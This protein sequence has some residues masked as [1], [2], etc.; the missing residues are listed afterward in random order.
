MKEILII[1]LFFLKWSL[2]SQNLILNPSFEDTMLLYNPYK[3]SSKSL[4]KAVSWKELNSANYYWYGNL[5]GLRNSKV[6]ETKAN[7]GQCF[8][9]IYVNP[10]YAVTTREFIIGELFQPLIKECQ[11]RIEIFAKVSESYKYGVEEIDVKC[12]SFIPNLDSLSN[13]LSLKKIKEDKIGWIMYSGVYCA[14]GD[15]KF[16]LIGSLNEKLKIFN[17]K[18][19]RK[20]RSGIYMFIDDVS[21]VPIDGCEEYYIDKEEVKEEAFDSIPVISKFITKPMYFE[22]NSIGIDSSYYSFLDSTLTYLKKDESIFVKINGYTDKLGSHTYN[23]NLSF[24]RAEKVAQYL[25]EKGI[26]TTRVKWYGNGVCKESYQ[27]EWKYRKVE[28][29]IVNNNGN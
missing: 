25:I 18:K 17:N 22:F 29:T 14:S 6:I 19:R 23:D 3:C 15:E 20:K 26:S 12:S 13:F 4:N 28:I 5:D 24:L 1:I 8:A 11:Y 21:V 27:E 7:L 2:C 16:I 10:D 9:G